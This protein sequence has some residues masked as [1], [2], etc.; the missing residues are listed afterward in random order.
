MST[1][2]QLTSNNSLSSLSSPFNPQTLKFNS[3]SSIS[4]SLAQQEDIEGA[5]EQQATMLLQSMQ[6]QQLIYS[7]QNCWQ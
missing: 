4:H 7:Q 1:T 5:M 3:T 2:N 6:H